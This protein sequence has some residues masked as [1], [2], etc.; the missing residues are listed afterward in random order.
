M[1]YEDLLNFLELKSKELESSSE[2]SFS[3]SF[4][5]HFYSLDLFKA[6]GF[7]GKLFFEFYKAVQNEL[8]IQKNDHFYYEDLGIHFQGLTIKNDKKEELSLYVLILEKE[9]NFQILSFSFQVLSEQELYFYFPQILINKTENLT[10]PKANELDLCFIDLNQAILNQDKSTYQKLWF[11][12][13]LKHNLSGPTGLSGEAMYQ[14]CTERNLQLLVDESHI[15][16]FSDPWAA[17]CPIR[18]YSQYLEKEVELGNYLLL[19]SENN[20]KI[21]CYGIGSS[22]TDM[23]H[24]YLSLRILHH[25]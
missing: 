15:S 17:L 1:N 14:L 6:K 13:G 8:K 21:C 3:S 12:N 4:Y 18:F 7:S 10:I 22:L 24:L 2:L 9:G 19:L 5:P 20:K 23:R 11:S 25:K 16:F